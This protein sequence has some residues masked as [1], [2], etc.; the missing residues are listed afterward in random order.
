MT[1]L[2]IKLAGMQKGLWGAEDPNFVPDVDFVGPNGTIRDGC[3]QSDG[4]L[5]DGACDA[6]DTD[7]IGTLQLLNVLTSDV[8]SFRQV[9]QATWLAG[10]AIGLVLAVAVGLGVSCNEPEPFLLFLLY[11]FKIADLI[12]DWLGWKHLCKC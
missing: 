2:K 4:S 11:A 7:K 6:A 5:W 10:V 9:S 8:R 12:T 1:N 3:F